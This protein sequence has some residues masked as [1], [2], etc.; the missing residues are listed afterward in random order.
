MPLCH[1]ELL[2]SGDRLLVDRL[3]LQGS[4]TRGRP[5]LSS[6]LSPAAGILGSGT[7][8]LSPDL[9]PPDGS[10]VLILR[11][12]PSEK[13]LGSPPPPPPFLISSPRL[14]SSSSMTS[15]SNLTFPSSLHCLLTKHKSPSF[16]SLTLT[17]SFLAPCDAFISSLTH[18][19]QFLG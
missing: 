4:W 17:F 19:L 18:W 16:C 9:L 2:V 8:L 3:A 10:W 11:L 14:L 7:R 15:T 12:P 13:T 6:W 1:T 5:W